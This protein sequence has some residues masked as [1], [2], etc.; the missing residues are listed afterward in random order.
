MTK[1]L[2]EKQDK[3]G[4]ELVKTRMFKVWDNFKGKNSLNT[5]TDKGLSIEHFLWDAFY[6][7]KTKIGDGVGMDGDV[8]WYKLGHDEHITTALKSIWGYYVKDKPV[9]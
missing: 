7:T 5:Y 9:K 1:G 4:F 8:L 2:I 3:V 6:A